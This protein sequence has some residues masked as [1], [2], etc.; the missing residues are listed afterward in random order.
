MAQT[1]FEDFVPEAVGETSTHVQV[2]GGG[3]NQSDP[4]LEANLDI[5]YTEGLTYPTPNIYY[6]TG[7]SPPYIPDDLTPTNSNEPYLVSAFIFLCKLQY[8]PY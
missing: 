8:W 3:N 2:N 7:G 1:F 6:S 5:Q 4:G